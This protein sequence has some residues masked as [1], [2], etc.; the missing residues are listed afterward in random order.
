MLIYII[1]NI[2]FL[3]YILKCYYSILYFYYFPKII[4]KNIL[5]IIFKLYNIKLFILKYNLH[6]IKIKLFT[7]INTTINLIRNKIINIFIILFLI[8]NLFKNNITIL[9]ILKLISIL[10]IELILNYFK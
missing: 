2:K 9:T 6:I 1:K 3:L 5:I 10:Y 7:I 4:E 8:I